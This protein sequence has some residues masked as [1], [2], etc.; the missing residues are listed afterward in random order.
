MSRKF[1]FE[2][3]RNSTS[4]KGKTTNN[5]ELALHVIISS[6]KGLVTRKLF[7]SKKEDE[8]VFTFAGYVRAVIA[9]FSENEDISV[10]FP[11]SVDYILL[12][13]SAFFSGRVKLE[14]GQNL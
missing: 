12:H 14:N 4:K 3:K 6:E 9:G 11:I 10:L 13:I 2:L 8:S 1:I 7:R 5:I